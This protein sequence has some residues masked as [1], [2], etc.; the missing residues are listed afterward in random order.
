LP[1]GGHDYFAVPADGK[2]RGGTDTGRHSTQTT[3]LS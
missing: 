3:I 1:I 2:H